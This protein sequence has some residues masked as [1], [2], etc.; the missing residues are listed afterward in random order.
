LSIFLATLTLI[1]PW[2]SLSPSAILLII[3][4]FCATGAGMSFFF[5]QK[6][7][8]ALLP[9]LPV[10]NQK[11]SWTPGERTFLLWLGMAG[12]SITA[13]AA[14]HYFPSFMHVVYITF[15]GLVIIFVLIQISL[16]KELGIIAKTAKPTDRKA[17]A[18]DTDLESETDM[19]LLKSAHSVKK[20]EKKATA[21]PK[22]KS[23]HPAHALFEEEITTN[24]QSHNILP[25]D[26]LFPPI[27]TAEEDIPIPSAATDEAIPP[28]PPSFQEKAKEQKNKIRNPLFDEPE[29][30]LEGEDELPHPLP[31]AKPK[32]SQP[33][34]P[35]PSK[36]KPRPDPVVDKKND[37]ND[38][39]DILGII[40]KR[41]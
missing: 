21:I 23:P 1:S 16:F 12:I 22:F 29:A 41:S 26:A 5:G 28:L 32:P 18:L 38:D 24:T 40:R 10:S 30:G 11:H 7:T 27:D 14:L 36:P 34:A 13:L 31:K 15:G 2:I 20:L 3:G 17:K 39:D 19:P 33:P 4:V 9:P 35:M 25:K 6:D 37:D 8:A